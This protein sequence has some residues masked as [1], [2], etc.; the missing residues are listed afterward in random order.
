MFLHLL[1]RGGYVSILKAIPSESYTTRTQIHYPELRTLFDVANLFVAAV[2]GVWRRWS[3]GDAVE[4]WQSN[5][6]S[7]WEPYTIVCDYVGWCRCGGPVSVSLLPWLAYSQNRLNFDKL[8]YEGNDEFIG[9]EEQRSAVCILGWQLTE[10]A[11][12]AD[13]FCFSDALPF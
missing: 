12:M 2:H 1:P 10:V 3:V 13:V 9:R 11:A 8:N 7:R 4:L 6:D 5:P